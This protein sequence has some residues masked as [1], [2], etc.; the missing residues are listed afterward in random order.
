[1]WKVT[2]TPDRVDA[3]SQERLKFDRLPPW[4][5][6]F[7]A[8]VRSAV[9]SLKPAYNQVLHA[10]YSSQDRGVCDVENILF[11]NVGPGGFRAACRNGLS[12]ARADSDP[13]EYPHHHAYWLAEPQGLVKGRLLARFSTPVPAAPAVHSYWW[14]VKQAGADV[15]SISPG[16]P[17]GLRLRVPKN[18]NVSGQL[19]PLLDG[20]IAAFQQHRGRAV[21]AILA[22]RLGVQPDRVAAFLAEQRTAVLGQADLVWPWGDGLQ[23]NPCDHLCEAVDLRCD[24]LDVI[25]GEL[26]SLE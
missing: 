13:G 20:V 18:F 3:W 15:F 24:A 21:E 2:S 22:G 25:E 7:R 12:F 26:L 5:K 6:E 19:K 17:F 9:S 16:R 4:M 8:G 1:M 14:A 10:L 23:W 11:Y